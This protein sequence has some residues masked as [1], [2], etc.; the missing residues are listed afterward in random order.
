[1]SHRR[2]FQMTACARP[3][4]TTEIYAICNDGTAWELTNGQWVEL[5]AI[6]QD[7]SRDPLEATVAARI[8]LQ[9]KLNVAQAKLDRIAVLAN[10]LAGRRAYDPSVGASHRIGGQ[11]RSI[12]ADPCEAKQHSDQMVCE[13]C[14]LGWDVNDP[15][16]PTCGQIAKGM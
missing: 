10:E 12:L 2:I 7:H 14:N 15:A 4:G 1:M 5:P 11:L 8:E 6:P 9:E 3:D 13:R 16:P